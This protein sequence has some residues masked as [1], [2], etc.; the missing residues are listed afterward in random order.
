[1][2]LFHQFAGSPPPTLAATAA[3]PNTWAMLMAWIPI[4][5]F[6]PLSVFLLDRVKT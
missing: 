6:G 1:M 3:G 2:F 5:M 4:F